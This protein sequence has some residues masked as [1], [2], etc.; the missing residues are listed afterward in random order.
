MLKNI[1]V[2]ALTAMFT[3]STVFCPINVSADENIA[4]TAKELDKLAYSGDDLGAVYTPESTTFKVWSPTASEVKLNLYAT[5]SDDEEGAKALDSSAMNYDDSNGVW[6]ITVEGDLKD[7]YYTYSVTNDGTTN[8]V[9]D[10]Y[11]KA[12][13]VNGNRGMVVDLSTTNPEGWE[14]DKRVLPDEQTDA[15]VWE[16]H[17]R[18]FSNQP[19][20]GISEANRG[21]FLAFT[22]TGTTLEG[23]D[24]TPTGIDYLKKLGVTH[25]QINPF[26]DF[27]SIDETKPNSEDYNWGYDPKNYNVPE[28]SYSTN[29]YDGNVRINEAKQ[30]IQA[31]HNAGIGVIMDVVYNHTYTGDDSFFNMTVPGYYYRYDENGNFKNYSGCGNDTASETA[32]YSK[33]MVDS[34]YYWATE[35]HLDGFR[36]DLMGLHDVNTMNK[37]REKL[38]TIDERI[39]IYGE[40]WDLGDVEGVDLATQRNV[41]MLKGVAAF[42]DGIRDT[43]KGNN[44]EAKGK[45][46]IQGAGG[47]LELETGIKAAVGDWAK[48]P[49]DTVTYAACHDNMTFYDKL[50]ASMRGVD[51][52]SL[53]RKRDNQLVQMNKLGAA[54][55]FTSQGM[56]FILAGEEMARSKDGDHNSYVSSPQL[57]QIDWKNLTKFGDLT[58]YYKGLIDIRKAYSPFTDST[59]TTIDS[60]TIYNNA[61]P[62][63]VGFMLE[64]KINTDNQW[65]KVICILNSNREEDAEIQLEGENLPESWVVIANADKAGVEKLAEI[66][67][68][69]VTVPKTSAMILVDKESFDKANIQVDT[70]FKASLLE[71]T[72]T[73]DEAAEAATATTEDTTAIVATETATAN[74]D[75][76]KN[77]LR[78]AGIVAGVAAAVAATATIAGIVISKKKKKNK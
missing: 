69:S 62:Y 61:G 54:A 27:G 24:I 41:E 17:V 28:G 71:N 72:S 51:D 6:S 36:F 8:E 7:T 57:N 2:G 56:S 15:I 53:Y 45:G 37:I 74:G 29:P 14:S 63:V 75:T 43:L 50:V 44:F 40:A 26:Y 68:T 12:A 20:S 77:S 78:T 42:N 73:K 23:S 39:I 18:D 59:N 16:V 10:I 30:M 76:K 5:G 1:L 65:D 25:V 13:G 11:A 19:E 21:K 3:F 64:N 22:E 67:G 58:A 66:T 32:M 31:L 9:V 46:F 4:A 38:D 35:Y 34:V 55:V 70:E 47:A 33:F 60:M 52:I 49:A 48:T